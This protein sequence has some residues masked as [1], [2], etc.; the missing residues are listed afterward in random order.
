MKI[1]G[2]GPPKG[3]QPSPDFYGMAYLPPVEDT[4]KSQQELAQAQTPA[5]NSGDMAM[6]AYRMYASAVSAS[7]NDGS[8]NNM[9]SPRP[10]NNHHH[11]SVILQN[12][13]TQQAQISLAMGASVS[14]SNFNITHTSPAGSLHQYSP[15]APQQAS[16]STLTASSALSLDGACNPMALL[17][18]S[19]SGSDIYTTIREEELLN[20]AL[21]QYLRRR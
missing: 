2:S 7:A 17:P 20:A 21:L 5:T 11:H 15:L 19:S 6:S 3:S 8:A 4:K 13:L 18:R 16:S 14:N 1:K 9:F 12:M 10:G